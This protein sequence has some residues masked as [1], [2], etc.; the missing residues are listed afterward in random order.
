[1]TGVFEQLFEII[2]SSF[3]ITLD[4]Q[5]VNAMRYFFVRVH[6]DGQL[7]GG[8]S[9]LRNSLEISHP[10]SVACA[11]RLS[12]ILSLRLGAEL[13]SDEQTYLALHVARLAED[14]GTSSD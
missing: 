8:M 2:D 3:G 10:D 11:E 12:Q 5:S 9:V 1:M 6:H 7:N 13:S 4:R 14:R